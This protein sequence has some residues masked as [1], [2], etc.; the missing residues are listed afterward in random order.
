MVGNNAWG[1][2]SPAYGTTRVRVT[3]LDCVLDDGSRAAFGP[4]SAHEV[5]AK[6]RLNTREGEIY[7]NMLAL[8]GA[9]K[10]EIEAAFPQPEVTRRNTGQALDVL[11]RMEP[12][13]PGGPPFNLAALLAGS[14]GTPAMT[15]EA[16]LNLVPLKRHRAA[17][18]PHFDSMDAALRATVD[19]LAREPAAVEMVDRNILEATRA[20]YGHAGLGRTAPASGSRSAHVRGPRDHEDHGPESRRT[21]SS[22][23]RIAVRGHRDGRVR[24][25]F[26]ETVS[27]PVLVHGKCHAEALSGEDAMRASL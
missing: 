9:H 12:L 17:V 23:P 4:L 6:R 3:A 24:G 11:C 20:H 22:L 26:L 15:V 1:S 18:V 10:N 25:Q 7:R 21:G 13:T 8:L 2:D 27:Q 19:L 14:E 16:E 5:A